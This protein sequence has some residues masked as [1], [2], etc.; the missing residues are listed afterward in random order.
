M[1]YSNFYFCIVTLMFML[2][3]VIN[4]LTVEFETMKPPSRDSNHVK[5]DLKFMN[6]TIKVI[7]RQT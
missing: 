7:H 1:I 3:E 6:Q 5:N 4:T 2:I